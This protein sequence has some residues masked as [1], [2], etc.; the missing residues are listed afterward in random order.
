M[1]EK[2]A[3]QKTMQFDIDPSQEAARYTTWLS[4]GLAT[5]VAEHPWMADSDQLQIGRA[6]V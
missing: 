4:H 2:K 6:H 5:L 3:M 1:K